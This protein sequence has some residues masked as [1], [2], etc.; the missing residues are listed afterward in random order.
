MESVGWLKL[1][2]VSEQTSLTMLTD[3][4]SAKGFNRPVSAFEDNGLITTSYVF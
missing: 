3:F 2:P 1:A 4:T